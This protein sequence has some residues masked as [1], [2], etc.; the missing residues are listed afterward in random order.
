LVLIG[1]LLMVVGMSG[2]SSQNPTLQ[3]VF[4]IAGALLVILGV[5]VF[6]IAGFGGTS[7]GVA[8]T[9]YRAGGL[10]DRTWQFPRGETAVA[11]AISEQVAALN[12]PR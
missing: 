7:G 4:A 8:V 9:V 2:G 11:R 1:L 10:E 6:V 3:I 12:A 5:G